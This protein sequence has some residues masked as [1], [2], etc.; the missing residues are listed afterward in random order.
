MSDLL[1]RLL[2]PN[3]SAFKKCFNNHL[4]VKVCFHRKASDKK[5]IC[6][7]DY[8]HMHS[9]LLFYDSMY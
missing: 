6:Y 9:L 4:R 2:F 3:M 7:K 1:G 8:L 5:I